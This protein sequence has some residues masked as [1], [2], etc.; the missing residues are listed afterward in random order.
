MLKPEDRI[1]TNLSGQDSWYL[2]AASQRGD[3][4]T[5]TPWIQKGRKAILE[6]ITASNLRGRG[7]AGFPTG[8]KWSFMPDPTPQCPN[9]LVVNADEG[10][11]GT[12]KDRDILRYEP[13]KLLEG[14]LIASFALQV[15]TCYI[16]VRG[17]FHEP[18]LHL[19]HALQEA[20]RLKLLGPQSAGTLWALQVHIHSGAGAYICGEET[21]LL[22]SLEG[23]RGLPRLK[24]P[25]PAQKG[26]YGCPTIINNVESLAVIPAILQRGA[27]WFQS[28]GV[29]PHSTGSKIFTLSGHIN[30]PCVVE[31]SL[32][33]PLKTMIEHHGK[34]VIGGWNNLLAVIPGG[35]STPLLP[36]HLCDTVTLDYES[37]E[38]LQTSLGTGA[39]IV[40]N[41]S[42]SLAQAMAKLASFYHH[43]SCGQ[44]SPCREGTGWLWKLLTQ[45]SHTGADATLVSQLE[46]VA[47]SIKGHTICAL[48][49]AAADPILGMLRHFGPTLGQSKIQGS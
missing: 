15:H 41:K 7:G 40:M 30:R 23:K 48:G 47:K 12:A 4:R 43:E 14:I 42:T 36:A 27:Q 37:L 19:N 34:G 32:G 21:A 28:L 38:H 46:Q 20:Y 45:I 49:A 11:P 35:S 44:C 6:E 31:E 22:E 5:A 25:F 8:K 29:P 16:Y 18:I 10:E 24:P 1:F 3:W 39:I 2:P 9:Y 33:V 17:E 13:H 26:L